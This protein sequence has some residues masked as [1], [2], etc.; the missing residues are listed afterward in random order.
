MERKAIGITGN[1]P[2]K[3]SYIERHREPAYIPEMQR[4]A[5]ETTPIVI[6]SAERPE[7]GRV[8]YDTAPLM[9]DKDQSY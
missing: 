1:Q 7:S 2:C 6:E 5:V 8:S 3:G 9:S 4:I